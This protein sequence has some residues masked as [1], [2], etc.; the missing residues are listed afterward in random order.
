MKEFKFTYIKHP[1]GPPSDPPESQ[2]TGYVAA[3]GGS[4]AWF[5]SDE[6]GERAAEEWNATLAWLREMGETAVPQVWSIQY[7]SALRKDNV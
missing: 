1:S 3:P 5:P 2:F 7:W 6:A 4:M